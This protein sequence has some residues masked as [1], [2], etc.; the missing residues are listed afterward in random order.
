MNCPN[1]GAPMRLFRERDY[2]YCEHCQSY[3]FPQKD[4][5]GLRVL[6][7]N[8]EGISCPQCQVV[9]NLITYDDFFKGYQC[10]ECLGLL[11]NRTTFREAIDFHRSRVKTPPEPFSHFRPDELDR[12]TYCPSCQKQMDT[13]QYNGPGNI[14]IDT[15]HPCDLIWLDY[16]ELQKVV[17]A[18]GR[19]RGVP[20]PKPAEEEAEDQNAA[21]EEKMSFRELVFLILDEIFTS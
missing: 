1:C 7:E 16:G 4:Q 20:R 12:A 9:L 17:S 18:P 19:D 13:F 5:D 11:F 14:I 2:Y 21:L 8:P 3:L 15:C 6:G 10:P